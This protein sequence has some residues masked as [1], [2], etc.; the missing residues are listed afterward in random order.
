MTEHEIQ[1]LISERLQGL[2]LRV[3]REEY[4]TAVSIELI[5]TRSGDV[6]TE[7]DFDVG[8]ARESH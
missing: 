2:R 4:S 3:F 6:L 5:D 1:L 7:V 8:P